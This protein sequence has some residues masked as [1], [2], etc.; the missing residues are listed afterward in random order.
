MAAYLIGD[1]IY[2]DDDI[3]ACLGDD[4]NPGSLIPP[5]TPAPTSLAPAAGTSPARAILPPPGTSAPELVNPPILSRM[6]RP[7]APERAA[8]RP[9]PP[10][11]PKAW[12]RRGR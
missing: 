6:L 3:A 8:P 12:G 4:Y 2:D 9:M 11:Q 7:F 5:W 10:S 1:E